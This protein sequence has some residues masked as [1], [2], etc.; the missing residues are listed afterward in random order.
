MVYSLWYQAKESSLCP[1]RNGKPE[2]VLARM[3]YGQFG[4]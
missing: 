4:L 3:T 1:Q 2:S